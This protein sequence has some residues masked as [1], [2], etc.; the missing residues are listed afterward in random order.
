MK[1]EIGKD[2]PQYFKPLYPE[3]FELFSHFEVTAG[4]PTVLFA[5]TT[6]K[7]KRATQ[8]LSSFVELFPWR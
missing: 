7:E 4:I 8:C 6:W 5:I 2:F 3:E 1:I